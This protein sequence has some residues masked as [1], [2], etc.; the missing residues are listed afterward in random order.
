MGRRQIGATADTSKAVPGYLTE[1]GLGSEASLGSRGVGNMN[2]SLGT[3]GAINN[4]L[5]TGP[6]TGYESIGTRVGDKLNRVVNNATTKALKNV[7]DLLG[8]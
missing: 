3:V 7:E 5:A 4:G 8:K 2:V 6:D 1:E